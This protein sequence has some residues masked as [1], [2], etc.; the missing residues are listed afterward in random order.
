M[1]K[2][3]MIAVTASVFAALFLVLVWIFRYQPI[4]VEGSVSYVW[5]RIGA[6]TCFEFLDKAPLGRTYLFCNVSLVEARTRI[7]QL[8]EDEKEE[9]RRA[10]HKKCEKILKQTRSD[11]ESVEQTIKR[12]ECNPAWN[13]KL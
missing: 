7:Q 3:Q 11:D 13:S 4:Q 10:L 9:E 5:D 12:L 1:T 2:G 8:E 6:K